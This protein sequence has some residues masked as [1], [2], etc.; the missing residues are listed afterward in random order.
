VAVL[1][2]CVYM[3]VIKTEM[4]LLERVQREREHR[5][6]HRHGAAI[7]EAPS[8]AEAVTPTRWETSRGAAVSQ[9]TSRPRSPVIP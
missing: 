1:A 9:E 4:P 2:F 3:F 5:A 8:G 7:T 6:G